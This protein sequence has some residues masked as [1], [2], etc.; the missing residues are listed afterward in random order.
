MEFSV[1]PLPSG[2]P[3]LP[4]LLHLLPQSLILHSVRL[5]GFVASQ[6]VIFGGLGQTLTIRHDSISRESFMPGI[7]LAAKKV[8]PVLC[9]FFPDIQYVFRRFWHWPTDVILYMEFSVLPLT[10]GNCGDNFSQNC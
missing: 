5:P 9:M 6:E 2:F 3:D 10:V 7:A 1:L 8:K 4:R